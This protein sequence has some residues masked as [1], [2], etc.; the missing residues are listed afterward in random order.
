MFS[1]ICFIDLNVIPYFFIVVASAGAV[2]SSFKGDLK[3]FL[4]SPKIIF[5]SFQVV[6]AKRLPIFFPHH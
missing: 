2:H 1:I 6:S 3:D 4:K 5:F